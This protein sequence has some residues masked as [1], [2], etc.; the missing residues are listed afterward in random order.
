[1]QHVMLHAKGFEQQISHINLFFFCSRDTSQMYLMILLG[2]I[3]TS[4][5]IYTVDNNINYIINCVSITDAYMR[6]IYVCR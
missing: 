3:Y 4:H 2:I 6:C 5:L 1:M